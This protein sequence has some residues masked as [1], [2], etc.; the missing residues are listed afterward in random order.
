MFIPNTAWSLFKGG[1]GFSIYHDH[2]F[3]GGGDLCKYHGNTCYHFGEISITA[4]TKLLVQ[5]MMEISSNDDISITMIM[6]MF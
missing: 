6:V 4:C 2:C 5:A 1:R 3:K